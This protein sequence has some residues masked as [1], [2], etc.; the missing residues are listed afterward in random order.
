ME[1]NIR[2]NPLKYPSIKCDKCSCE[3]FTQAVILKRIPGI[4]VGTGTEDQIINLPVFVCTKCGEIMKEDRELYKINDDN[5]GIENNVENNN[6]KNL[7][8]RHKN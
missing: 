6:T 5:K 3:T 8:L 4:E 2:I 1:N 7:F